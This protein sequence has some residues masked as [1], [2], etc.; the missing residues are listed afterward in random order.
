MLCP[1]KL[2]GVLVAI[3]ILS[4]LAPAQAT[5]SLTPVEQRMAE[6]V[7]TNNL[8][9]LALLQQLVD[10]NSGT[11]HLAGVLSIKDMLT[12][13]L[14]KLGFRVKWV[15]MDTLTHRAG[16]LVA[17][18]PCPEG[19]GH[20]G[21][22]LLLVGH[23]DT[24]FE[25]SS[26]FQ[27][28]TIVPGSSGKIATGP[29][30]ADM[31]GGLVVML[32]ALRAMESAGV[33]RNTEIR[34][35]LSGDEERFGDPVELARRDLVEAAKQSDVALEFEPSVR[36]DG[37]DSVSISRRSSTTWHLAATGISGHS[38][39]IFADRL[40]Y[41]AIYELNRILDAFR[42]DLPEDGLTYSVGLILGGATAQ[43]NQDQT[44]GTATGKDN[45]VAATALAVGDLRTLSNEQTERV[46]KKMRAIVEQHLPRTSATI[47]FEDSYPAMA[48]SPAGQQ[49]FRDWSQASEALGLGPVQLG[50]PMTRGA[51]DISFAAPYVPGLVGVGILG[52]GYHAEGE[53]AFLDSL[54]K[55]A[56]RDA[57]LME[58]LAH[59]P[60]KP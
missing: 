36:I 34:I 44:G 48:I 51:G 42:R 28:Y 31:K 3:S 32:A 2:P 11:M 47:T 50:G 24:V 17:E 16:D 23:M 14:E 38:S 27:R 29:G 43:L 6:N 55:Q 37:Q 57:V 40:G 56:K 30:V 9:D 33:L 60:V 18:H 1:L 59:Q 7:D 19:Q 49:L 8:A 21:K 35:V 25:P 58:R 5:P 12:P 46:Q 54:P 53:T 52:E 41:G 10:T 39:Q 4:T 45:V 15:P 22:R 13:R 20:C 26:P